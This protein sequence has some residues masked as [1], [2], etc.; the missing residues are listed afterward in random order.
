M[1]REDERERVERQA[2]E[3][4]KRLKREKS[5]NDWLKVGEG[6]QSGREWALH[7][8]MT[9]QPIGKAYNMAF[10]EWLTRRKLDDMDKGDRSRLFAVM[11]NLGNIEQWRQT[12]TFT[13]RL[14]LNHPNAVWRKWKAANEPETPKEPKPG[15]KDANIRLQEEA[16]A[17][18]AH[19]DELQASYDKLK[20]ENASLREQLKSA[21]TRIRELET[22]Q[23]SKAVKTKKA[24]ADGKPA[25][26]W[27]TEMET[28]PG[29]NGKK[30]ERCEARVGT[31]RAR[32]TIT[33]AYNAFGGM[34]F[35]GYHI[36]HYPFNFDPYADPRMTTTLKQGIKTIDQA[37]A[38]A[39]ADYERRR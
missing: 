4:W 33:P 32:Y 25:L 1:M 27:K 30:Y 38:I 8:A 12:L 17:K 16:V 6:L 10:G 37:K 22:G 20:E 29:P 26:E 19:L 34:E 11:D 9:N 39:Q 5:W 14:K 2:T 18:D 24:K 21:Q 36:D 31:E 15:L 13:E 35:V 3:A 28:G 7:Q 23:Q